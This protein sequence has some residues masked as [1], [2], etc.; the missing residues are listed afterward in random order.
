MIV[1]YEIVTAVSLSCSDV[2]SAPAI[3]LHVNY[4]L[5]KSLVTKGN[6]SSTIF[7][8]TS[9]TGN[10]WIG[11]VSGDLHPSD[12]LLHLWTLANH[13]WTLTVTYDKE[14]WYITQVI[15][16]GLCSTPLTIVCSDHTGTVLHS[17]NDSL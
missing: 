17:P 13:A 16:L 12:G 15:I 1:L 9:E 3:R 7:I 10:G 8:R 5:L 14:V 2:C 6:A 4:L 11:E